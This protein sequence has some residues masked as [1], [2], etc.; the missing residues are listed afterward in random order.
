MLFYT[1]QEIAEILKISYE[2]A[3]DV[4][5][6]SGVA[7]IKVGRQYRVSQRAFNKFFDRERSIE[8]DTTVY[9]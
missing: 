5:K 7:Y 2:R 4:V 1:V 6:Y 8:I 9:N 3:L